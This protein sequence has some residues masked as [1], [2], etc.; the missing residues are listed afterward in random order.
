MIASLKHFMYAFTSA[1]NCEHSVLVG[2]QTG[3]LP[4]TLYS[5]C[6]SLDLGNRPTTSIL[7]KCVQFSVLTLKINWAYQLMSPFD[8]VKQLMISKRASA[9]VLLK[10]S[11]LHDPPS[12]LICGLQIE[13]KSFSKETY[14]VTCNLICVDKFS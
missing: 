10:L 9:S 14:Q 12:L 13:E 5:A 3:I 7:Q 11:V 6:S 8:P 1:L 4:N 2:S